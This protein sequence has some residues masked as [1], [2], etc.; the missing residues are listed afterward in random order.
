MLWWLDIDKRL[1]FWALAFV[2]LASQL[3]ALWLSGPAK[4]WWTSIFTTLPLIAVD[5]QLPL[6]HVYHHHLSCCHYGPSEL[7]VEQMMM[8]KK[9]SHTSMLLLLRYVPFSMTV[10]SWIIVDV[11]TIFTTTPSTPVTVTASSS[12]SD[13][14]ASSWH[15][16]GSLHQR[17]SS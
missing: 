4:V 14:A 10:D 5:V 8:V 16:S 17:L 15:S 13:S 7:K 11:S 6:H 3:P 2:P 1:Q 12:G 9:R